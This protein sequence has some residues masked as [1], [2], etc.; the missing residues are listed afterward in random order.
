[1]ANTTAKTILIAEDDTL[2]MGSLVEV[3]TGAGFKVLQAQNGQEALELALLNHPDLVFTDNLMP[4]L[5][6]IDM[7]VKLR[8]DTWGKTVPVIIMTNM[9]NAETLNQSLQAGV[10]DFVMKS[11]FSIDRVVELIKAHLPPETSK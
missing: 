1:M 10:T 8:A 2:L 3:L 7:V 6:G 5:N 11:D 9:Y 4:V